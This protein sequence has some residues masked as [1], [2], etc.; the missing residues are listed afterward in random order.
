MKQTRSLVP[1]LV[2]LSTMLLMLT[3]CEES[4]EEMYKK[5]KMISD[6]LCGIG[7]I[8]MLT[9]LS[10]TN[11][12][13][14]INSQKQL[15]SYAGFDVVENSSG[16][17]HGKTKIS[18]RG[19]VHLRSVMYMPVISIISKKRNPFFG[20]YKRLVK[21]NGGLKKK[22]MVA[23]QRKLLVMTY[24]LW[25]KNEKFDSEYESKKKS[26]KMEVVPI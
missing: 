25:K 10:E 9:I 1:L 20:F 26:E 3:G 21:R 5:A 13:E 6:S 11:G 19:N 17:Y 15:E 12:F 7:M 24:I 4:S 14:D 22:A 23:V 18:K 8:S 16:N 2:G